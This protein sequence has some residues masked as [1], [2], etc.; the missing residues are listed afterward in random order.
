[1]DM[2]N[3]VLLPSTQQRV[4]DALN[5]PE[6]LKRCI[7]GCES[8]DRVDDNAYKVAM[9]LAIGPV[10][11]KFKGELKLT[12]IDAPNA[13]TIR[14]EGQG[15]VA[16][17][18]K[19]N[20]RVSLAPEDDGTRLSYTV[21]AQVGGKIAQVGSRLIDGA[22]KKM[23]DD[24]FRAFREVVATME[25]SAPT[26]GDGA[27]HA[28][29]EADAVAPPDDHVAPPD[30][31][32]A[33]PDGHSAPPDDH[34]VTPPVVDASFAIGAA[35]AAPSTDAPNAARGS[36]AADA[37]S[38]VEHLIDSGLSNARWTWLA[39]AVAVAATGLMLRR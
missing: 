7:A 14:F 9:T 5:D 17:F 20:A 23:A 4:W 27:A 39:I 34:S 25:V 1:M 12:D 3:S 37:A 11:A 22:S 29:V 38:A 32:G 35:G 19:G 24:F 31:H 30:D 6:I 10:K 15:G 8:I 26:S 13:Y 21:N 28:V 2:S 16:G 18:G 36:N 33:P